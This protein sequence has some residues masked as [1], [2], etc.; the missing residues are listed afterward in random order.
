MNALDSQYYL[1]VSTHTMEH[2]KLYKRGN[3]IKQK[4][5]QYIYQ[6]AE[7]IQLKPVQ[8][9]KIHLV[10]S[11]INSKYKDPFGDLTCLKNIIGQFFQ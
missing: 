10:D 11:K 3:V 9:T 5:K 2:R 7:C 6:L 4:I 1:N 8:A